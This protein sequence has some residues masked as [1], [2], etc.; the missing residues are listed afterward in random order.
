MEKQFQRYVRRASRLKGA[1]GLNLMLLL[2]SRLDNIVW[3]LGLA[4]TISAARQLIVH[5]HIEINGERVDRPSFYV[6]PGDTIT[7]REKSRNK[8]FI[9]DVLEQSTGRVLPAWLEFDPAKSEGKLISAPDRTDLP[10]ELREAAI[11][12]FYSQKL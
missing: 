9:K 8:Q 3:R 6:K 5:R 1:A 7:V 10:F 11:I 12:E 4:A 2:Q